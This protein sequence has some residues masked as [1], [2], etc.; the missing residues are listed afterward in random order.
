MTHE[1]IGQGPV[2]ERLE[3]ELAAALDVPYA[4]LATSGSAALLMA[5]LACG[6]G[7]DDEVVMPNRT[8]VATAH[9]ALLIGARVRL[10]DV[11]PGVPLIDVAQIEA[12]CS[13]RTKAIIPVHLNGRG[14]EMTEINRIAHEW[15][16]MVVEDACQALFSRNASGYLGTQSDIGC[17]SL[18]LT[19]LISTGQGGFAVTR[20]EEICR[21][22]K[23]AR[24]HGVVDQF[25][26]RW[27]QIGFNFKF[28]DL[29][30]SFGIAQLRRAGKR[31]A[32]VNR[33][34]ERYREAARD[35]PFLRL[36]PVLVERGEVPIYAEVLCSERAD[37]SKYLKDRG[38]QTRQVPPNIS[39]SPYIPS[40][41][42][43]PNSR[44]F[45]TEGLYLPCGPEQPIENVDRVIDAL[46]TYVPS[47]KATRTAATA[48]D[49]T[50]Q[51][52]PDV[53]P[54]L[55]QFVDRLPTP[56]EFRRLRESVG[57]SDLDTAAMERGLRNSIYGVCACASGEVVGF[58]RLVGDGTLYFDIVDMVVMPQYQGT[59]VGRGIVKHLMAYVARH[60]TKG[61]FVSLFAARGVAEFYERFGFKR[62]LPESPG[63]FMEWPGN[64]RGEF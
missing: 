30:A 57:W 7:R 49:S 35:L 19:K 61:S 55:V 50:T 15:G 46:R 26:D 52:A 3:A 28:T 8:W 29:Q 11:R 12:A 23:L 34:Y 21:K 25:T 58:G 56:A 13:H 20:S 47:W 6:V 41:A 51:E 44:V 18:G 62:R 54:A 39:D 9:A 31:I 45:A 64:D 59:G 63:M 42:L 60:A 4:V 40:S 53:A 2:T 14:A 48:G 10:V 1:H 5:L 16:I 27:N 43:Y 17:F 37:L 36:I 38:I 33:L 24:N 32:H 22:L